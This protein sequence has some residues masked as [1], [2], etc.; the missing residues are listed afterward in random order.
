MK[1]IYIFPAIFDY[2]EDGI[3]VSFPDLPSCIT[4]GDND[5]EAFYMAKDVLEGYLY[6]AEKDGESIPKPSS[7]KAIKTSQNQ[8]LVLIEVN[9]KVVRYQE[10]NKA[11]KK[12]ITIP[13][14][15][16]ELAQANKVNYS[17]ALQE[18]LKEILNVNERNN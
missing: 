12:T 13:R 3:S 18:K 2:A 4:C 11:I 14:W 7:L 8:R 17:Q 6:L 10:D 5:E 1:D 16:E 15:L 9:M